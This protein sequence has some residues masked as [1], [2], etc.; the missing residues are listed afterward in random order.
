MNLIINRKSTIVNSLSR[1]PKFSV[2]RNRRINVVGTS[3]AGKTSLA[4]HLAQHLGIPHVELDA[5]HWE[6]NWTEATTEVFR[7]R[8][9]QALSGDAWTVDGNY[10]KAR[11]LIF[12][13]VDTLIWLDYSLPVVMSRVTRRTFRRVVWREELWSG[14]RESLRKTLFTRDSILWW[15]FSTHKRRRKQYAEMLSRPEYD[16]LTILHFRSPAEA[17]RWLKSLPPVDKKELTGNAS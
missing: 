11:D 14:N 13:R 12:S 2:E 16:H 9:Q 5:L 8:V 15:A 17:Q 3:G 4:R 7:E 6:P 1:G 10:N